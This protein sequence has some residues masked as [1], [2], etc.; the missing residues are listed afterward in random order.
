MSGPVRQQLGPT[1]K[2]LS[3]QITEA[4][5]LCEEELTDEHLE[6]LLK[7]VRKLEGRILKNLETYKNLH[8]QLMQVA[9]SDKE[10]EKN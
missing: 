2:R 5:T 6:R 7:D 1:K 8:Q 3:G 4:R 9:Q 10:E